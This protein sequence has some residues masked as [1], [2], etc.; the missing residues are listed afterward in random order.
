[1]VGINTLTNS[2]WDKENCL[3]NSTSLLYTNL[4][5]ER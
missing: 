3:I 2:T 4:Q 5:G 1:M